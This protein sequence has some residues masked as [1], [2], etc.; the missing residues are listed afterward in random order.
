MSVSWGVV[1]VVSEIREWLQQAGYEPPTLD[2][3]Y[4]TLDE[5]LAVVES[6][7]DLPIEKESYPYDS[8]TI[9]IGTLYSSHYARILGSVHGD[10]LFHFHFWGGGCQEETMA[11]I[12]KALTPICG[13]LVLYES[14]A[15]TPLLITETTNLED[16]LAEWNK[17]YRE[18]YDRSRYSSD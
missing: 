2:G 3:R 10:D 16:A 12:L 6:F 14:L 7:S 18:R 5:L 13:P 8:W 1:P 9:M 4:P 11:R 17:R 15:A